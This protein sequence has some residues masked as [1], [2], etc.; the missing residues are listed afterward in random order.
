[1]TEEQYQI[2]RNSKKFNRICFAKDYID[3][4]LKMQKEV[5]IE[6]FGTIMSRLYDEAVED[7]KQTCLERYSS[8]MLE[9]LKQSYEQ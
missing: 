8:L 5:T 7:S 4:I 9:D 3:Q 6:D 1:M 2:N